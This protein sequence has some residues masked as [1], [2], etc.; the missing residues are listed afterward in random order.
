D[1]DAPTVYRDD[2]LAAARAWV[3]AGARWLHVVDLDGA[4]AGHPVNLE[5]L[6]R[7]A[8]ELGVPV[9][10][11]GGLRSRQAIDA[12][13]AAG[14]TRV[15]VGTAAYRDP[16]LLEA[17][18]AAHGDAVA[19]AVDVR[20]G[21]VSVAGWTED[22]G[23]EPVSVLARLDALGVR[24]F[25]YTDVDRDGVLSGPDLVALG[26]LLSGVGGDLIY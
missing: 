11:G 25:V 7:I 6:E 22:T 10:C 8:R 12:A 17:A 9:Q 19:V 13:L 21:R 18:L 14:A 23:A 4:R 1:F 24:T 16:A 20:G 2:P 3:D 26:D 15:V 5:A